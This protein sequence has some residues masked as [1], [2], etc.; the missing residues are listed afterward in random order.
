M[1][2]LAGHLPLKVLDVPFEGL[3]RQIALMTLKD[4]A[5]SPLAKLFVDYARLMAIGLR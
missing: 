4:R 5:I 1:A 3:S 2:R